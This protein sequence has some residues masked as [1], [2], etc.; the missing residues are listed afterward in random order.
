MQNLWS[1]TGRSIAVS[2]LTLALAA[3]QS[4]RGPEPVVQPSIPASY[5][6]QTSGPSIAEQGYKDYFS[7]PRL[8]Q[9]IDQAL[10]NN[11]DLRKAALNIQKAQAQYKITANGLLPTI[12]VSGEILQSGTGG[13]HSKSDTNYQAGIGFTD[14][15]IDFWGRIRSLKDN[16]LDSFLATKSA[17]D[18]T[19]IT[20]ISQVAEAWVAYSYANVGL[21]IANKTL[22]AQLESMKLNQK[23]FDV[24]I[25][26]AIGL[27]NAK[28]LVEQARADVYNYQTQVLQAKNLLDLLV[29]EPVADSLLAKSKVNKITNTKV[30]NSGLPSDLLHNRPD[31]KTAEYQLSAAGANIGAARARLFPTI[32][33]TGAAGFASTDLSDLFKASSFAW[34]YGPAL[35]LPIFDWGTRRANIKISEAD[36]AI[37]LANYEKSI[38]SAFREVND[39]LAVRK[40]IGDRISSTQ[41][42]Y[43]AN[44]NSY[45]L[46]FARFR[47]GIDGFGMVLDSQ[48][49]TYAAEQALA[50]LHQAEINNQIELYKALG[51]GLKADTSEVVDYAPSS[52]DKYEAKQAEHPEKKPNFMQRWFNKH[53][54]Q[55]TNGK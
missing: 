55:P 29:G 20:L 51:G 3:C 27:S 5:L 1:I 33:L 47:A 30:F 16:A 43:D 48:R 12:G 37:A 4:F 18:S 31:I 15:E 41:R 50:Q 14:Y 49:W 54:S 24:G 22:K 28:I 53:D 26:N 13:S 52:A 10:A 42:L 44:Y 40:N 17:R 32:T 9:V 21:D 8:I 19:Q 34:S 23:R 39:A 11:R 6:S 2:A 45:K 38:Q 25:D 46:N 36:R 7:D 35:Q